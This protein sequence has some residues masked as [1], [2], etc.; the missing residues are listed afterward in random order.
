MSRF[1]Y[2]W[3]RYS[4]VF[5]VGSSTVNGSNFHVH[6]IIQCH[7]ELFSFW[8]F[9]F[10]LTKKNFNHFQGKRVEDFWG[11][12]KKLLGDMK[13]LDSLKTFDKVFKYD[14][15]GGAVF[16][17]NLSLI[18]KCNYTDLPSL[19][20]ELTFRHNFQPNIYRTTSHQPTSKW[21]ATS[22]FPILNSFPKRFVRLRQLLKVFA[23]GS[24]LSSLTT[25][26]WFIV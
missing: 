23:N 7:T 5:Y 20:I 6:C 26:A 24:S 4:Y 15:L 1:D 14:F 22:S 11:P 16:E 12:S 25:G 18:K 19:N 3:A 8:L 21:S 17:L 2:I 13:F 9:I 10:S